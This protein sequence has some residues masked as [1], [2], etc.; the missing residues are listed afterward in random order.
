M[1]D[2]LEL[3]ARDVMISWDFSEHDY[4]CVGVTLLESKSGR[5]IANVLGISH[6][7]CGVI[8]VQ[9]LLKSHE[10]NSRPKTIPTEE[11]K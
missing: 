3:F 4:P 11:L 7:T 8:S 6:K 5:V 1:N 9:Q 2:E 10:L